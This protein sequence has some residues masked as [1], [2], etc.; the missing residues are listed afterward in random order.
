MTQLALAGFLAGGEYP[1][2]IERAR[3]FYRVRRDALMEAVDRHLKGIA[4]VRDRLAPGR[5]P[6]AD[7]RRPG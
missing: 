3:D 5:A 4:T 1:A 2:H 6:V 7:P